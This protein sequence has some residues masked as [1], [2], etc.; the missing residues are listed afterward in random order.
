M[1][2]LIQ[3]SLIAVFAVSLAACDSPDLTRKRDAQLLEITQLK[4][5][6]RNIEEKLNNLPPDRSEE[7]KKIDAEAEQQTEE[8]VKLEAQVTALE[9]KKAS[10]E[11][12]FEEYKRKYAI[13]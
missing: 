10:L 13:R 5:E 6:L 4:G 1:K 3:C 7:L 2:N 11:K 12:E 8:L 9:A